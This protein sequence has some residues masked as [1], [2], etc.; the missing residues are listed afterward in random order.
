MSQEQLD[1]LLAPIALYP[2]QLLSQVLMASTYP[3]DIVEAARFVKASPDLKGDALV[4]AVKDKSWDP[5]VQSLTAFPQVLDM[6]N[7]KLDWTQQLGEAFID[8]QK[9]VL[10]TVQ[11]LRTKAQ[12]AGNLKSNNEQKVVV[13]EKTIIIEPAKPEVVYVPA[14]NPTVVYG[15]W[16]AP[17]YPPYFYYP[18]P[19]YGYPP[20]VPGAAFAAG[21][22]GFGIGLAVGS[23][24]WGWSNTNWGR[25]DVNINVNRNNTFI[26][27]N[28]NFQ[29]NVRNGNWEHNATQ[30]K[31]VGY[32][33]AGARQ[34]YGNVDNRAVQAR[35][36]FRGHDAGRGDF[37]R[38]G[39]GAGGAQRDFNRGGAGR[40]VVS[41]TSIA[42]VAAR[43]VPSA[44][45]IAAVGVARV[46]AADRC[47]RRTSIAIRRRSTARRASRRRCSPTAGPRAALRWAVEAAAVSS[48]HGRR[49]RRA[50]RW[51]R[52]A[53]DAGDDPTDPSHSKGRA[54]AWTRRAGIC[55]CLRSQGC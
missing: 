36:D 25:G 42:A 8:D 15:S 41:K 33:D 24:N 48:E 10:D 26:N 12:A 44:I 14:Y 20:Y 11:G 40:A 50:S 3:L 18:P 23:A 5:S 21:A 9:R 17:A 47:I 16:W 38:G 29:N 35:Q 51:R 52:R 45:S 28:Q 6:M 46:R 43:V 53:A 27:N 30:R 19:V 32:K 49:R 34:K 4:N 54:D 7:N 37:N 31:G 1:S 22:I 39:G 2:D 55:V 13:Q